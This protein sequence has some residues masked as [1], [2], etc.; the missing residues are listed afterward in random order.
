MVMMTPTMR[1]V[2]V[3]PTLTVSITLILILAFTLALTLSPTH[4]LPPLSLALTHSLTHSLSPSPTSTLTLTLDL[5]LDPTLTSGLGYGFAIHGLGTSTGIR[6]EANQARPPGLPRQVCS[7]YPR[8][9]PHVNPCIVPCAQDE[10]TSCTCTQTAVYAPILTPAP[11][12][13]YQLP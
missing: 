10:Y 13:P 2:G 7:P 8:K 11:Y 4:T 6:Q 5:I 3:T 1:K 12:Q 9:R